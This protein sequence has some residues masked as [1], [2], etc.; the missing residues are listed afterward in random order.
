M[1]FLPEEIESYVDA[2]TKAE[3]DILAQLNRETWQK[4]INP[5]MLSGHLQGR[6]LSMFS[7]MIRPKA[8][9]EIGTYT[10][11]SALCL[12][13]G[14][15]PEGMLVTI[16]INDELKSIQDKYFGMSPIGN[17]IQR[18]FG[19]ALD[20]I[21]Q[22]QIEFDLVFMD[23]DKENYL[24]YYRMLMLKMHSGSYILIDNVLWSGKVLHEPHPN[25]LE[26]Q[27]MRELNQL[28]T[29]DDRVENVLM[30]IRDGLMVLRVK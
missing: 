8:I 9:L 22:L 28:V 2:H 11:Y 24:N 29:E 1:N 20:I 30:P 19:N 18:H 3:S 5:R 14:L 17:K 12:A 6:V 21:P 16:D 7:H 10:G 27:V 26:T 4:V 15:K 23:A 13:E 25:D